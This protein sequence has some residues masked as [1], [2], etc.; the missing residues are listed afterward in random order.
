M[1]KMLLSC[2]PLSSSQI[3]T[4]CEIAPTLNIVSLEDVTEN[5]LQK[6]TVIYGWSD[7]LPDINSLPNLKWVQ[8]L[9][10]GVNYLPL[11]ELN[12]RNIIVTTTSGIH[13][14]QMTESVLGMLFSYTRNIRESILKQERSAWGIDTTGTDLVGKR[15]LIFGTGSIAQQLA[16]TLAVFDCEVFG[17]NRSG[18][19]V[20]KF[21]ETFDY[22]KAQILMGSMDIII[23]LMPG[24][25]ETYHYFNDTVFSL[26]KEGV[27]F[28]NMGRGSSVDTVSLIKH[29]KKRQIAFAALDVFEE[30][31]LP[32][33]SELWK[34]ENVLVTPHIS[35]AT[36]K[37]NERAFGIFEYNL[38]QYVSGN[39]M[40]NSVDLE[41]GY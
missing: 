29:L 1:S 9:S 11:D 17:V 13:G 7:S 35:G 23:N 3:T 16:K 5:D 25:A 24:T 30:E 36:D 34:L 22:S 26:M 41:Q 37:Y 8:T 6:V 4:V 2:V 12:Q 19:N 14:H 39:T 40:R 15:V 27:I 10:A 38:E 33:N 18:R 20:E 32:K 28:I 21:K 31:P